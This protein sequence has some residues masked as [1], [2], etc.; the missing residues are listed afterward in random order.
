MDEFKIWALEDASSVVELESQRQMEAESLL[1]DTLVA[2]PDLLMP[3]LKLGR[4]ADA[5]RGRAAGPAGSGQIRQAL[6]VRIEAWHPY[7]RGGSAGD[8]L[9]GRP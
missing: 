2:N 4:Q 1:E 8:R 9:R 6:A 3:G 7:T 5:D